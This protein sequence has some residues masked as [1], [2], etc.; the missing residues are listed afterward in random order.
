MKTK[1]NTS[2]L[3]SRDKVVQ[4]LY[5]MELSNSRLDELLKDNE[6]LERY[7]HFEDLLSG[8]VKSM[9]N[10]DE[11]LN[12]YIDRDLSSIDPVEKNIIRLAIYELTSTKLDKP[13]IID[14]SIRLTKKYGS[15]DGY[16]YVNAILDKIIKSH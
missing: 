8:V 3:R 13:I 4:A 16:K 10:I 9:D 7:P 15:Q 5:E 6:M 1:E 11:L 12:R 14:E 2:P